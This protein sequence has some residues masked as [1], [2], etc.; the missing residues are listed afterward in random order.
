MKLEAKQRLSAGGRPPW[1]TLILNEFVTPRVYSELTNEETLVFLIPSKNANL[2]GS[3]NWT[4]VTKLL[5]M[6]QLQISFNY[7]KLNVSI[8]C[9]TVKPIQ[10]TK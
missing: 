7:F 3:E 6:K 8:M 2:L 10:G 9:V 4:R 5:F 1:A